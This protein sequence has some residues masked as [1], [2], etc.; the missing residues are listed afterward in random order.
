MS[1]M[2]PSDEMLMEEVRAG[3]L[4]AFRLLY[5]RHQRGV[6]T[7]LLRYLGYRQLAEDLLQETFLRVFTHR[8][9]YRPTARFKTWLF[10][11][12]RNL[13]ID[14][15]RRQ[16]GRQEIESRESLELVADPG[17]TPLQRA[18]AQELGERLRS[19]VMRLPPSQR[20]VLLLSRVAGLNHEEIAELT[21]ASPEAVRVTLHR[22]LRR[23]QTFL[24]AQ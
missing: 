12:A 9:R 20:E 1:G 24:A 11:I 16:G 17:A 22:A 23:I 8:E 10:T 5:D 13:A 2:T 21:G 18:E 7:F 19:A 14:Q 3:D 15:L 4:D 6:F